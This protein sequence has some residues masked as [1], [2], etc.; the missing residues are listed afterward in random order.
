[1]HNQPSQKNEL[2]SILSELEISNEHTDQVYFITE[3]NLHEELALPDAV[4]KN[5]KD[6]QRNNKT[7]I[8]VYYVDNQRNIVALFFKHTNTCSDKLESIRSFGSEL[9]Q[10]FLEVES[11]HFR[12]LNV[13]FTLDERIVLFE[14]LLL[15][16]YEFNKYTKETKRTLRQV[17]IEDE[18][19][20]KAR[21]KNLLNL[22]SAVSIAKDLVNEPP[23]ALNAVQFSEICTQLGEEYGFQVD[24]LGQQEIEANKMGGLLAVNQGSDT[25]PTFTIMSYK[26][27]DAIN[28]QPLVLI[29]KGVMFDTGGYSLKVGG[30]MS[31]MKSDM[32]G[33]ASVLGILSA[34]ALNKLPYYV[35]GLI[36]ATD[37]KISSNALVVDDVITMHDGTTVE[38]QNTDAEGRLVL[39]DALSY[40][41][42]YNPE[43]V[44]DLATLT[45][46]S[47][48]ITGSFGVAMVGNNEEFQSE[49]TQAGDNVYERLITLPFWME[50]EALLKSNVA[51]LK[52]IGGP[53]GGASTA[54]KFLSH[55]TD[56]NWIH[57]DIAGASFLKESNSYRQVGGTGVGVRLIY[58]FVV[59]RCLATER[60]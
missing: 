50:F 3:D 11:V 22:V 13:S 7:E 32:A 41:K 48:A 43:L 4:K 42:K 18:A 52:N 14:G 34:L 59:Q 30:N 38:I 37:N 6:C 53:V 20:D 2:I 47:A 9:I 49:L 5:V 36:P 44:I 60:E 57:L 54:G 45:G 56:Y 31:S 16:L 12:N 27:D 10:H 25:P 39:A 24:V 19:L 23:N 40:A 29:G 28:L 58:E 51:D 46:A 55:F 17:F 15:S 35:I 1:M 33:G 8:L 26:P 21:I